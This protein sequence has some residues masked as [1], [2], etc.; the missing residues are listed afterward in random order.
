MTTDAFMN[1]PIMVERYGFTNEDTFEKAFSLVS[2]E[3]IWFEIIAFA[4]YVQ[5]QIFDHHKKEVDEALRE[6]IPH[7]LRWYRNKAKDFQYGFPLIEDSD[8]FDNSGHTED[9]INDSKIIKY[10]A[11]IENQDQR[12]LIVK[13]ATE[14]DNELQPITEQQEESFKAYI[15]EIKDA[16]VPITI[17]NYLPDNLHLTIRIFRNPMILDQNGTHI[18]N[19]SKPVEDAINQF[20]RE[21]PF[22]GELIL[23]ELA[24][25]IEIAEGVEIVQIDNA[26]TSWSPAA[27]QSQSSRNEFID[28]SVVPVSGYFKIDNFNDINY[29]VRD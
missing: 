23:Q 26:E 22:N 11:V 8:Q 24:N 10:S 18:L 19:G 4:L 14:I 29:V 1:D 27:G 3:N 12:R 13:I 28:V 17:V 15:A 20:L 25:A 9:E 2:I 16:G 21:L 6:R 5:E 7:T